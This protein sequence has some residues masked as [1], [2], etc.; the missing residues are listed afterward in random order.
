MRINKV[1]LAILIIFSTFTYNEISNKT[2]N[3]IYA[4][5][6]LT[7]E[8]VYQEYSNAQKAG[9]LARYRKYLSQSLYNKTLKMPPDAEKLFKFVGPMT[10][11]KN[12]K[13]I[14]KKISNNTAVINATGTSPTSPA[15]SK[16]TITLVKENGMWKVKSEE[17]IS[18]TKNSSEKYSIGID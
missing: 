7:P 3:A 5:T 13:I 17:W 10:A 2:A 4:Q 6:A 16:G 8:K 11:I 9:D 14:N 18:K 1:F 12:I 15:V